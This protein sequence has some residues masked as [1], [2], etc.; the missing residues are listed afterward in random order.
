MNTIVLNTLSGAVSEYT[1]FAFHSVTPTHAGAAT[2]LFA[3]G[4]DLD[5]DLP[6]VAEVQTASKLRSTTLKKNMDLVYFSMAGGGRGLLTVF[7]RPGQQ[8]AYS[9]AVRPG[10]QSRAQVGRGI[11]ENYLG[12]GFSNPDGDAFCIDRIEVLVRESRTRRI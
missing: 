6:I 4:G 1:N 7:G 12:F 3:F 11:R 10:G 5:I 8:W 9:F 2:G